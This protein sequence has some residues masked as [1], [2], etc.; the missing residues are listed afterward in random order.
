MANPFGPTSPALESISIEPM[1][2]IAGGSEL[3]K[4]RAKDVSQSDVSEQKFKDDGYGEKLNQPDDHSDP[5]ITKLYAR[6]QALEADRESMRQA[7]VSMRTEK[8]QMVLLKEIAQ[9]LSKD[10]IPERRLPLQKASTVG[11]FSFISLFKLI[12]VIVPCAADYIFSFLEKE[13]SSKQVHERDARE[14][15]GVANASR[16]DSTDTAMEISFKNASVKQHIT[17]SNW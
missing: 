16:E 1:L 3:L 13:G 5:G 8:A 10:I 15:H 4:D 9:H 14:H 17:F 6:L 12:L 11:A 2:V 7:I